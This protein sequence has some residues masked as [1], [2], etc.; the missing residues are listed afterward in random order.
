MKGPNY[1][2]VTLVVDPDFG[3]RATAQAGF[4]PLWVIESPANVAAIQALWDSGPSKF[5][6]APTYFL[7]RADRSPEEAAAFEIG[8]VDTHHPYWQTF[9]IIGVRLTD[10]LLSTFREFTTGTARETD[11]GFVFERR[12][13]NS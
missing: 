1:T 13:A 7:N 4:G 9:E 10:N 5:E 3:P 11:E 12:L 6:N 8:T 2:H